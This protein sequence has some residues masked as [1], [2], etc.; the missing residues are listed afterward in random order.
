M[1]IYI[2]IYVYICIYMYILKKSRGKIEAFLKLY[3]NASINS[4]LKGG[5]TALIGTHQLHLQ[6]FLPICR[7]ASL[8]RNSAPLGPHSRTMPRTLRW[9]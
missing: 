1:Y 9:S 6:G 3:S 2:T 4:S 8:I 5:G 7:G